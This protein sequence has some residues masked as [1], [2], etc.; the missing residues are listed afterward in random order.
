M[1]AGALRIGQGFDT[2]RFGTGDHVMLGG[3]RIAHDAGVV[4]HSDGDVLLHALTDALLGA[5]GLGDIG[6]IFPD[7]DARWAGAASLDLLAGAM[8]R[9]A[10][11]GW[12]V[13]NADCTVIA[14][15]P[16]IAG[17]VAEIRTNLAEVLAV[18]KPC[19]NVKAT[20]A[21]KMGFI[22]RG[23]GI[24][25]LAVVLLVRQEEQS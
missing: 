3:V 5:A 10:E 18:E 21:E 23:E 2:H 9:L 12:R 13:E 4:A 22:G 7:T 20:T 16:K 6:G 19:V 11:D 25:A 8:R 17:Y 14:E 15:R 1:S 24:A